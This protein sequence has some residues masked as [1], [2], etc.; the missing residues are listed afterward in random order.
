MRAAGH[1][2]N[3]YFLEETALHKQPIQILKTWI[4]SVNKRDIEGIL[5]LY[6]P[7]AILIPTFSENIL[8]TP[9]KIRN[10][11]EK[12]TLRK[13]LQITVHQKTIHIQSLQTDIAI[14]SGIYCWKFLVEGELITFEAR[15]SFIVYLN[16]DMPIIHHHSS[17][18]P[19][20]I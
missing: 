8:N 16:K 18:I 1:Q 5:S 4:K 9:E 10:Y 19:R 15:F 20:M 12:L 2:M 11:F 14:I 6:D 3:L 13:K 17:Q 7:N